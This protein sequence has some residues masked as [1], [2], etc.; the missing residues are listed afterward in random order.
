MITPGLGSNHFLGHVLD[1]VVVFAGSSATASTSVTIAISRQ[2]DSVTL[3]SPAQDTALHLLF[4]I[5]QR[6]CY[7]RHGVDLWISHHASPSRPSTRPGNAAMP[8]PLARRRRLDPVPVI[9]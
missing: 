3:G 4:Q 1:A 5:G 9:T 8:G 2:R 6:C 7:C